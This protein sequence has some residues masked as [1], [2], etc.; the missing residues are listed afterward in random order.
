M[1]LFAYD[2]QKCVYI[3]IRDVLQIE[4]S[5]IVCTRMG[6]AQGVLAQCVRHNAWLRHRVTDRSVERRRIAVDYSP[7]YLSTIYVYLKRV[8]NRSSR[9]ACTFG[10]STRQV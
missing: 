8:S 1:K 4:A 6:S 10:V 3:L 5:V 9:G 7:T 2:A